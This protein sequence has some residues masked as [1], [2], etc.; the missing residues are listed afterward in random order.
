MMLLAVSLPRAWFCP[1]NAY[2]AFAVGEFFKRAGP[3][4]NLKQ[5]GEETNES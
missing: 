5:E 4:K 1:L 2:A 3:R